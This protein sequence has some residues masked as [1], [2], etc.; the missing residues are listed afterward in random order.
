[1]PVSVRL[2]PSERRLAALLL[3]LSL[4]GLGLRGGRRISPE[5]EAWLAREY[6]PVRPESLVT[7]PE[8]PEAP[9]A[10]TA[11]PGPVDPSRAGESE[12]IGLPG[13]GPVLARRIIEDRARNG[14]Y[15]APEDLL[16]V[17]GIG[18]ATLGRMR[19]RLFFPSRG[20]RS[21]PTEE[22]PSREPG[23]LNPSGGR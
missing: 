2:T 12:L 17:P 14:P 3:G 8:A 16:R 11:A 7:A 13:V 4:L 6:A 1:M 5:V 20:G 10:P 21:Q 18:P 23:A 22:V 15:R 19:S 9:T